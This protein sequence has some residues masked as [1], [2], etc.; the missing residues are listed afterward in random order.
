MRKLIDKD[1]L[2]AEIK[3]RIKTYNKGYAN[4]D[5]R[6]ADALEVLLH[7]IDTLEVKEVDI[8]K[9]FTNYAKDILACDVQFEPFTH[10]YNCAK[11]F[12]ELGLSSQLSWKDIELIDEIGMDFINSEDS[13]NLN[14]E[15]Y[16]TEILNRFKAQKGE[17]YDRQSTEN[18]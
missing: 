13:D 14:D 8:E 5:D 12:F 2:V 18:P 16:Y 11:H 9:E 3:E 4:G 7:D 17:Y 1:A 15:E 6:R 10:L